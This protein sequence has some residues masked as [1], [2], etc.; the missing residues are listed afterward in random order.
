MLSP[1]LFSAIRSLL[2]VCLSDRRKESVELD[3]VFYSR[4]GLDAAGYIHREGQDFANGLPD[5]RRRSASRQDYGAELPGFPRQAPVEFP[6][7]AA[8]QRRIKGVEQEGIRS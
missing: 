5:V 2:P 6:P 3:R 8:P 1:T 4:R 7:R